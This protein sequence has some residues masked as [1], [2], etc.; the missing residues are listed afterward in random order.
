MSRAPGVGKIDNERDDVE[1]F[2]IIYVQRSNDDGWNEL[3]EE[4]E[5]GIENYSQEYAVNLVKNSKYRESI[6]RP[7]ILRMNLSVCMKL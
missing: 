5:T 6:Q 7:Q 3:F 2:V 4:V 1:P